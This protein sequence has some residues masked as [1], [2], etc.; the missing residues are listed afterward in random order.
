[1]CAGGYFLQFATFVSMRI[2][3]STFALIL[4]LLGAFSTKGQV[5]DPDAKPFAISGSLGGNLSHYTVSGIP[6]RRQPLGY[7]LFGSVNLKIYNISIPLSVAISQQGTSF[8][9]PF[10][11]FGASP[12][13]KWVKLHL[14][15]RN[16]NY[17][18]FTLSGVSFL[19][20][21]IE[22]TP[23][24]F[25]FSAMAGRLKKAIQEPQSRF[26]RP[27]YKRMGY[28]VKVGYGNNSSID[29]SF[30]HAAD[31]LSSFTLNDS[32]NVPPL[33][34]A[35]TSIGLS[36]KLATENKK[37]I[38]DYDLGASIF[39]RDLRAREFNDPDD[40]GSSLTDN[41]GVNI[42]SNAAW[43]GKTGFHYNGKLFNAGIKYRYVQAGYQTLGANYLLSDLE[44]ITLNAGTQFFENKLA[45]SGSY[46]IQNNDL[47]NSRFAKTGR[48][49]GSANV[50]YRPSNEWSFNLN[51]SNFSIYQTLLKDSLFADSVVVDQTNYQ[52]GF[53]GSYIVVSPDFTHT[54]TLNT[55][56]QNLSDKRE[57]QTQDMGNNLISL[58]FNYG[59]RLNQKN[60]GFNVGANYQDF[61]SLLTAQ[62][63]Y[64]GNI[65][66]NIH[67]LDKRLTMRIK[68]AWNR[69]VLA[70]YD[71]DIFNTQW[72]GSFAISK[73]HSFTA[74]IGLISR[75]GRNS[76]SELRSTIGYRMRF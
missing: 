12:E 65:G 56:F 51:F 61:S 25:R 71:D 21:G 39:T 35:S 24:K 2:L 1:M 28:G 34:Q 41:F 70:D 59:I 20:G 13:Y 29:F 73:K 74:S 17:S 55:N 50:S 67:L 57:V 31:D 22:L 43:A 37:W 7:S 47:S 44:M 69:S 58:M 18:E 62:V 11:R 38:L 49:I 33:P 26:E 48:N 45:V 8:S 27:Q 53:T 76:F 64:G 16:L 19:G 66:F 52:L 5:I 4:F 3:W 63:R 14:G 54:Y 60:Y 68:Q 75:K 15:Y 46:G 6:Q 42:S 23:G 10:S 40:F 32:I 36:G 72:S 30:F 9:Q